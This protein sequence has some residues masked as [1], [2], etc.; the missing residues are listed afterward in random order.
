MVELPGQLVSTDWLADALGFDGLVV[1]DAS[2][3]L[4]AANRDARAEFAAAHIPGAR[5]MDLGNLK[6]ETSEVPSALPRADQFAARMSELGIEPNDRIVIYDDSAIKSAARAWY[7]FAAFGIGSVALLDGG[8]AKW[9][10]EGRPLES[11]EPDIAAI[12]PP[13]LGPPSRLRM[14]ADV[15]ANLKTQA[16]Q[17]LDARAKDRFEGAG[18]DPVHGVEGGRI[19]GSYNLPFGM[20]FKDDGTFKAPDDIRAAFETAGIDLDRPIVTTC[21]S[22]VTASVLLFALALIGKSDWA[23]YDGSWSDWG[24]DPSTPKETGTKA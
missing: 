16:E 20:L 14:K 2:L 10:A 3:H 6:D 24:G 17:M 11:S 15:L 7:L 9:R 8:L 22:G 1:V 18:A 5:F 4:P 21:G 19:P 13:D 12:S 23:L